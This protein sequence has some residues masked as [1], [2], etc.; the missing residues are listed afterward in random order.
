MVTRTARFRKSS[1]CPICNG[2]DEAPRGTGQRCYGFLSDDGLYAHCTREE[3]AGRLRLN[4]D[5]QTYAHRLRGDCPCGGRHDPTP[6]VRPR[7]SRRAGALRRQVAVY[8][9]VDE[10]GT[11]LYQVVRFV[12]LDGAKSF[13]QRRPDGQGGW[14]WNLNGVRR[15]L[16]E[17]PALLAAVPAGTTIFIP[18]GEKDCLTLRQ[19][20]LVATTNSEGA[21]KWRPDFAAY[22]VGAH[23]VVLPD[24]DAEG[25]AH[26]DRVVASLLPVAASLKRLEL[27]DLPAKGDVSDWFTAGH[28]VEE[29]QALVAQA[30]SLPLGNGD[31]EPQGAGDDDEA[32]ADEPS[33]Q[34]AAVDNK[35]NMQISVNMTAMVDGTQD[36]IMALPCGP[37]LFQRA[38]QLCIIAHGIK[39]PR[40]L[41]RPPEAP[42]ILPT[43]RAYLRELATQAATWQAY[44]KRRKC[45]NPALPPSWVIDTLY[46]RPSWPFPPLEGIVC[47]PTLRPDGS[48]LATP[49]YDPDTGLYLD[50][51]GVSYPPM[52]ARPSLDDARTAIKLLAEVFRDFPFA[53][54]PHRSATLAAAISLVARYAIQGRI[55]LYAVRSTTRGAG[56]GL[57]VDAISGLAMGR[58]AP[59]WA[60]VENEDE[61]RKRL[62][63]VAIAGDPAIHIDN[64]T[65]PFG[66]AP[67]DMAITAETITDRMLGTQRRQEAPIHAVFFASGNNMVF[68]GDMARR[69]VPIDLDPRMERPEERSGF[70]HDPLLAWIIDERPTLVVAA[71]TVLK[72]YFVAD[73]PTQ[74]IKPLG[75]FE[76]WSTLVRQ[77]LIWAGEEDPCSGR[78]D[79]EAESDP[80][81]E[82]LK[83]L[84]S[85]WYECYEV[86]PVTLKQ[87]AREIR[88]Y[89]N[90]NGITKWNNLRDALSDLDPRDSG[91][92]L[93]GRVIGDALRVWKGRVID[94]KR[95]VR[96][97]TER[98][99]AAEWRV[100]RVSDSQPEKSST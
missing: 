68:R 43:D 13:S 99:G 30:P 57:L 14:L 40:W 21:G 50:L 29:L 88:L 27:P 41:R 85:A 48:L 22:F 51:N 87:V 45:W 93:N 6:A 10:Q 19:R 35:P 96:A 49:G 95:F 64:V 84:L 8:E 66:S 38:R 25:R 56:K 86:T 97:G 69:V 4:A 79:I 26:A 67:L 70:T 1:P 89:T 90:D 81:F 2:F 39:P 72:A 15:V 71:L 61:E 73:C 83:T 80:E 7:L 37:H 28:T 77:A 9:Y 59:R 18:E 74:G 17:L 65:R 91:K 52:P 16:Y 94:G 47:A 60:Q 32:S 34:K 5:S 11:L 36:A 24:N 12:D 33:A 62:L 20:E 44:D 76:Q 98:T 55:P 46:A 54:P 75:S 92:G 42:V 3:S 82:R 100:E 23:V 78:Q 53:A 63:T 58:P 31:G